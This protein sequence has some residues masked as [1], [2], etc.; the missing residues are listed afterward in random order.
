M[1]FKKRV[2]I[3]F[4]LI[5]RFLIILIF[6]I[7]VINTDA[8][9]VRTDPQARLLAKRAAQA[10]AYRNLAEMVMG[11]KLESGTTVEEFVTTRDVIRTRLDTYIK[12]AEV[13]DTR[14]LE[15]GTCEVTIRLRQ[16]ELEKILGSR[17]AKVYGDIIVYGYGA[18]PPVE[19]L[20]KTSAPS[21]PPPP[22]PEWAHKIIKVTGSGVPPE[23]VTNTQQRRL[24]A[25]RAAQ[26]DAYR[27]LAEEVKGLKI[28]ART[29]VEEFIT[30]SDEIKSKIDAFIRGARVVAVRYLEDDS[31]EVDLELPLD[32]L[33]PLIY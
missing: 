4:Y 9:E 24:M 26:L 11:L 19:P 15:D 31:C 30:T 33:V 32:G 18:P 10:D 1:S 17:L 7:S 16:K 14:Y 22:T 25:K 5:N 21:T 8:Q 13:I 23:H 20:P 6:A 29:T 28:N 2:E 3:P 12:R 27:N